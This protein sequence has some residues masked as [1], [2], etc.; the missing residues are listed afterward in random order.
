MA[1]ELPLIGHAFVPLNP[2]L[3]GA[4][5]SEDGSLERDGRRLIK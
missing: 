4:R 1:I 5:S 3:P 2:T